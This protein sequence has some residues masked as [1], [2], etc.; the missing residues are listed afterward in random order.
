[1]KKTF[2]KKM[3]TRLTAEREKIA[4]ELGKIGKKDQN[5]KDGA[6]WKATYSDVGSDTAED[7]YEVDRYGTNL[8]IVSELEKSLRDIDKALA[9]IEK[10]NY[11]T[12]KYCEEE[13]QEARLEARPDSSSCIKCKKTFTKEA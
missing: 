5:S 3:T 9:S 10:G 12:C 13:I 2:L 6:D 4:A 1:M 7:A 11:G 8:S